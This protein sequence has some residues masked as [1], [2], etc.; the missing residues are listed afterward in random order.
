MHHACRAITAT[1][2]GSGLLFCLST[3]SVPAAEN[4]VET[5]QQLQLLR[6]QNDSLQQQMRRQAEMIEELNRK[7]STLEATGKEARVSAGDEASSPARPSAGF[8]LGKVH[9]GGEGAVGF[10]HSQPQGKYP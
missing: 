2:I 1:W 6:Q 10:F 7:V 9:L 4:D 3:S 8:S 5:K